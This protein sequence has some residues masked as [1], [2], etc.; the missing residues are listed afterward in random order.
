VEVSGQLRSFAAGGS[1]AAIVEPFTGE[2]K[3]AAHLYGV[4]HPGGVAE[5]D[6]LR[7]GVAQARGDLEDALRIHAALVGTAEGGRD[8][9]LAA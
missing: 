8:H 9:A 1:G 2:R 7:A 3:E 5:A 4:G 6:L